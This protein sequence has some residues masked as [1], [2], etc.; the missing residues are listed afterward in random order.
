M[1]SD[2][3]VACGVIILALCLSRHKSPLHQR[4]VQYKEK[5]TTHTHTHQYLTRDIVLKE[6]KLIQNSLLLE[7][8]LFFD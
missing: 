2:T 1:L 3:D 4:K 5:A 7:G 6:A 8:P